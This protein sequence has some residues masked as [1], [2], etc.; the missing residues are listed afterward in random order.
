MMVPKRNLL[1]YGAFSSEP[2]EFSG[3]VRGVGSCISFRE[4]AYSQGRTV[5]FREGIFNLNPSKHNKK[6]EEKKTCEPRKDPGSLTFHYTGCLI[7]GIL[8]MV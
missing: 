8:I 6:V 5:S 4:N 7:V 1:F 3:G 2:C